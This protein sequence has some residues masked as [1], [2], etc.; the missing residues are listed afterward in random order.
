LSRSEPLL[1]TR[2][3]LRLVAVC[4]GGLF[5]LALFSACQKDMYDQPRY[6]PLEPSEIFAD[7]K[8]ARHPPKGTLARD[9][10][11]ADRAYWS[12]VDPA[13]GF[14]TEPPTG[15]GRDQIERGKERFGVHCTPCHGI[16]GDGNGM[17]VQRG[18]KRA[19]SFHT[20]RLRSQPVGYFVDVMTNGFGVM[21]SYSDRLVPADRWAIAVYIQVLQLSQN[22]SLA[23]LPPEDVAKVE[24]APPPPPPPLPA[25]APFQEVR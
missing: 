9:D 14:V 21:P 12:G 10:A 23:D 4:A 2:E 15:A 6:D 18:F 24:S 11:R 25:A 16:T 13:G 5:W 20:D 1:S 19:A 22:V 7:G 8:S 3:R 17:I